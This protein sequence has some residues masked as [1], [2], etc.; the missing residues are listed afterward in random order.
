VNTKT[1]FLTTP[2]GIYFYPLSE[3]IS[4]SEALSPDALAEEGGLSAPFTGE[5]PWRHCIVTELTS[6]RGLTNSA[7]EVEFHQCIEKLEDQW[8]SLDGDFEDIIPE[9]GT[10]FEC[11]WGL[12]RNFVIAAMAGYVDHHPVSGMPIINPALWNKVLRNLGYDYVDDRQGVIHPNEPRQMVVLRTGV[13]KVIDVIDR[14]NKAT[15]AA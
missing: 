2:A 7:T 9:G 3:I 10:P 13:V 1:V 15:D 5:E 12:T 14:S 11:I 8:N 4:S 6:G